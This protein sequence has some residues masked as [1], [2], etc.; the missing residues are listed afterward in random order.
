M[1]KIVFLILLAF[2]G[3]SFAQGL[4]ASDSVKVLLQNYQYKTALDIVDRLLQTNN[5]NAELLYLKGMALK[6]NIKYAEAIKAL[7][8]LLKLYPNQVSPLIEIGNCYK[9]IGD[10]KHAYSS[11]FKADSISPNKFVRT[12]MANILFNTDLFDLAAKTYSELLSSDTLNVFLLRTIGRCYDKLTMLDSAMKYY[13]KTIELNPYD[14]HSVYPLCNIYIRKRAYQ[15]GIDIS[16]AYLKIDTT[17]VLMKRMNA[18]LYL[19]NKD[20]QSAV[21]KFKIC[22]S[23]SD[24]SIF[25]I[26][27][28]GVSYYKLNIFD[29][30]KVYLEMAFN[31][32]SMDAQTCN[33]LGISCSQSYWKKLG[34]YYLK[35]AIVLLNPDPVFLS[36]I[37]TNLAE[38]C[39][40][41]SKYNDAV[42]A[43]LKA[44]E[45]NPSDTLLP[46]RIAKQ[47]DK[48]LDN[49]EMAIKYYSLFLSV[50]QPATDETSTDK[51]GGLVISYYSA[52]KGRIKQ[53]QKDLKK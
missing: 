5:S 40:G 46:Y 9:M 26:K 25:T 15:K 32:D 13:E 52:A 53:L 45:I 41:Y 6:G 51:D 38:A 43:Y 23:H 21:S 31:R 24:T 48:W 33:F 44:Y 14:F 49:K 4:S 27:Y 19:L 47:Y 28:L 30:A 36:G 42:T 20:Y 2:T 7:S 22:Y 39:N 37:Y 17:E 16:E 34:I 8:E 18:Y 50:K 29:T 10:Y 3:K 11:L 12:E 1:R 35:K